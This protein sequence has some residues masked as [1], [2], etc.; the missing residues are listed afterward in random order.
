MSVNKPLPVAPEAAGTSGNISHV[1]AQDADGSCGDR[2]ESPS[3]ALS[4]NR[5]DA[6]QQAVYKQSS[7][8]GA[9]SKPKSRGVD[10]KP[11]PVH[12][13]TQDA[14]HRTAVTPISFYNSRLNPIPGGSAV[15]K[16]AYHNTFQGV[17]LVSEAHGLP[18]VRKPHVHRQATANNLTRR[19]AT[20]RH[21]SAADVNKGL[22]ST[23][24]ATT[25][26]AKNVNPASFAR[27]RP[28]TSA[29][30]TETARNRKSN[31]R[32]E[33]SA[34]RMSLPGIQ[35][36]D[37]ALIMQHAQRTSKSSRR[38]RTEGSAEWRDIH[39]KSLSRVDTILREAVGLS[40]P[41]AKRW[42][43]YEPNG[44]RALGPNNNG[45]G[46]S[47]SHSKGRLSESEM[48]K[49]P[50]TA[51][52]NLAF[53]LRSDFTDEVQARPSY[54]S[55][56]SPTFGL[57]G[58]G[59]LE[60]A[61]TGTPA[62]PSTSS[63]RLGRSLPNQPAPPSSGDRITSMYI[64]TQQDSVSYGVRRQM[65][66]NNPSMRRIQLSRDE[67]RRSRLFAEYEQLVAPKDAEEGAEDDERSD[68]GDYADYKQTGARSGVNAV[69]IVKQ[70]SSELGNI[71]E[72][73]E[74]SFSSFED[75]V[76]STWMPNQTTTLHSTL[77][78]T[79]GPLSRPATAQYKSNIVRQQRRG[80]NTASMYTSGDL[81]SQ[82][83]TRQR[84]S[85]IINQNQHLF[86]PHM[87]MEQVNDDLDGDNAEQ[88]AE[89]TGSTPP[90]AT[91]SLILDLPH[92]VDLFRDVSQALAERLPPLS[93]GSTASV[94]SASTV[95]HRPDSMLLGSRPLSV[96]QQSQSA[97]ELPSND[98]KRG[99]YMDINVVEPAANNRNKRESIYIDPES[100][101]GSGLFVDEDLPYQQETC[102]TE[103]AQ[104][105]QQDS[106]Q[107]PLQ[108]VGYTPTI[109]AS[110]LSE[111]KLYVPMSME[112]EVVPTVT[113]ASSLASS[114]ELSDI[115][116]ASIC[117]SDSQH[118][119]DSDTNEITAGSD[120]DP[121][122]SPLS[123][124]ADEAMVLGSESRELDGIKSRTSTVD[125]DVRHSVYVREQLRKVE[126]STPATALSTELSKGGQE[127]KELLDA[128][129]M[130][131]DFCDQPVDF[132]LRQLFREFQL[133]SESQQID[134]VIMGFAVR[135]HNCNPDLFYSADIVYA[136][137]FAIL[138]LHTDAHN[139]KVK[140]KI[141][142][143]QFTTRAKLLDDHEEGQ[144]NEM[145]DEI[146][147]IIYD[148]VTLVEFEYSPAQSAGT[149]ALSDPGFSRSKL[150]A[151]LPHLGSTL[152]EGARDQSPGITGWLR[153]MFTPA[154]T[155]GAPTKPS[156]SSQDIP[157]KEQYSYST[158]GRRRVGSIVSLGASAAALPTPLSRPN[159]SHG[160][161]PR[162]GS[163]TINASSMEGALES[164][165][166]DFAASATLPRVRAHSS[167]QALTTLAL[168]PIATCFVSQS[169][170]PLSAAT[171]NSDSGTGGGSGVHSAQSLGD[172]Y[173]T[174]REMFRSGVARPFKSSP[175]A[176]GIIGRGVA[177]G[178]PDS[179]VVSPR[180]PE[181]PDSPRVNLGLSSNFTATDLAVPAQPQ[182][183]ESI[184]LKGVKSH[185]KRR[186]S[187]RQGRPLSGIIYQLPQTQQTPSFSQLYDQA[188]CMPMSPALTDSNDNALLRVDMS[189][190]VSRKM[191]RLDNGR[192]GFVRRWKD[193]WMVLS[194]SRLY[195]FRPSDAAHADGQGSPESAI[196]SQSAASRSAMA[197]Q[198]IIS[199]RNGVAIVDS[200]YNKYPHV[201]RI[202]V[203]N[204]SEM[205]VKAPDD[206]AV[207]E[208]MARINCAAAFK[209]MEI[210]RRMFNDPSED[211]ASGGSGGN[212]E[213]DLEPRARLLERKLESLDERLHGI[214][215]KLERCLR[216]FKQL[217]S[218]VPLTRQGRSKI[219]QYA[220]QARER[221][222]ELYVSEQRLTCYKD[223]LELDLAIEYELEG[224]LE[225][226][227][228]QTLNDTAAE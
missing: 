95:A 140:Q 36:K 141:T 23:M 167:E 6:M 181:S 208:W 173:L 67:S 191:E 48:R 15:S 109:T 44:G 72:E 225:L 128:Y 192:R 13:G 224:R 21:G 61:L 16:K 144:E 228:E 19:T 28:A 103:P 163:G 1:Y 34:A 131:F 201:F 54:A 20:D 210:E 178:S 196:M 216:L 51:H 31:T 85:R 39:V 203:D 97:S 164:A 119:D 127:H 53:N 25:V 112:T 116:S 59:K 33:V 135:Y 171:S 105:Q 155:T 120:S 4:I 98:A 7:T 92:S 78:S 100:L 99:I 70:S 106:P 43:V 198:T 37:S 211:V 2:T 218:M 65:T 168:S 123:A 215:D 11:Q 177:P 32:V 66:M 89:E 183:V 24:A 80:G 179:D 88:D 10:A 223:V 91:H 221:L 166:A 77:P 126:G 50:G 108:R 122:G 113:V 174:T 57:A 161:F 217:A 47:M 73:T 52:A 71:A 125:R 17:P 186:I 111:D 200:G 9:L 96:I 150:D 82:Q 60:P 132:A 139:P 62:R 18:S 189:G 143:S 45:L 145:F 190:H 38:A 199:L 40:G 75:I 87:V 207:A 212:P 187:L 115:S 157:S 213:S 219:V 12:S 110:I 184:R 79:N 220:S 76:D 3:V 30:M 156:L 107:E 172:S 102:S 134:R 206:D 124:L 8:E 146:L 175:L 114:L 158:V 227:D 133:P 137:A 188:S 41:N 118:D 64:P 205:L 22:P 159:T 193:I 180:S 195:L 27:P 222:K 154:G 136:Y 162:N 63:A 26:A 149:L 138:L 83:Q 121:H 204:G 90:S 29:H 151:V 104:K 202:L 14:L 153:R 148:N 69:A 226:V 5:T 84:W 81:F 152:S 130:R 74:G 170:S 169:L 185:V 49:R 68:T 142:K 214:D 160:T 55:E 101:Y 117:S 182:M 93:A 197:I 86:A 176:G 209:T 46:I 56:A 94:S 194:G 42:T 35:D 129:L 147:D 165:R 58:S